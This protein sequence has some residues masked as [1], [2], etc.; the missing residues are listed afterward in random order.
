MIM[1]KVRLRLVVIALAWILG[2]PATVY[3]L[4]LLIGLAPTPWTCL[5]DGQSTVVTTPD[6]RFERSETACQIFLTSHY[7]TTIYGYR[8]GDVRGTALFQYD[9]GTNMVPA[10][11]K[12]DEDGTVLISADGIWSI[13]AQLR[14]WN[15]RAINYRISIV[16]D[17]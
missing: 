5:T 11:I 10:D 4:L 8:R 17:R 15:D 12:V 16:P 13:Y 1:R 9:P 6:Y 2:P 7:E 14:Q 3:L